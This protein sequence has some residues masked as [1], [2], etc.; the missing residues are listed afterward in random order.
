MS[1][2]EERMKRIEIYLED[3]HRLLKRLVTIVELLLIVGVIVGFLLAV[4]VL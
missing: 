4:G 2:K 1:E 3:I